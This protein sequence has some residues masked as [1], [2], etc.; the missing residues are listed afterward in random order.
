MSPTKYEKRGFA[1]KCERNLFLIAYEIKIYGSL[2][3]I[4]CFENHALQS[5]AKTL[6]FV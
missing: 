5:I 6:I 3:F 1:Q 2:I 4:N